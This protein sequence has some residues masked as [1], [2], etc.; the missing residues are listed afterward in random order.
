MEKNSIY[1]VV[2]K[3]IYNIENKKDESEKKAI[4]ASLRN[5]K[6]NSPKGIVALSYIFSQI[7]EEKLGNY[8]KLNRYEET[9]ITTLQLYAI[10]SQ[11]VGQ[12]VYDF[13]DGFKN[14]G[15]NLSNIRSDSS[16][17]LD[18]VVSSMLVSSN[19]EKLKD[20]VK[21]LIKI[22]KTKSGSVEKI[23]FAKLAYDLYLFSIGNTEVVRIDWARS[24]FRYKEESKTEEN[25][26]IKEI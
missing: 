5:Y 16:G 8:R 13:N 22:L 1:S 6:E 15:Y 3:I 14:F 24:Y 26:E 18:R 25:K 17:S 11:G 20:R 19:Y 7:P 2:M 21:H 4:L 9:I 23:N 12:E 10:Y